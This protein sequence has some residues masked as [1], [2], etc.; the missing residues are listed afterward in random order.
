MNTQPQ[1]LKNL[2]DIAFRNGENFVFYPYNSLVQFLNRFIAKQTSLGNFKPIYSPKPSC[3]STKLRAL[4]FGCGIG[5]QT[6]LLSEFGI[7]SYGIDISDSAIALAKDLSR[8]L[9][10]NANFQS[11]N[12][13][14]LPF[15]EDFFDFTISCGAVLNCMPQSLAEHFL[16]QIARVTKKYCF[17]M[18]LGET[19]T[20]PLYTF[21]S[22]DSTDTNSQFNPICYFSTLENIHDLVS[23]TPFKI[24]FLQ[25]S[26]EINHINNIS[27]T[28]W[29]LILEK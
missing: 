23:H 25:E 17:L 27:A 8:Q 4:D 6:L 2:W 3:N 9:N 1:N 10:L 19:K 5:R 18:L 22:Q 20:P 7:E 13:E 15:G 24:I 29:N 28:Y 11:S 12:S 16:N 14:T 21:E 26:K